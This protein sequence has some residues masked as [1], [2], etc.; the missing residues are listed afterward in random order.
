MPGQQ[1]MT[2][3]NGSPGGYTGSPNDARTCGTNGGC[4]GGGT[5]FEAGWITTDIPQ[6]GYSPGETYNITAT[7]DEGGTNKFG[8]E[9]SEED[10]S[11]NAKGT[12][13]ATTATQLKQSGKSITHRNN[14]TSGSD[15]KSW[16]FQWEAPAAGAGEVNFYAAFIAANGNN[17]NSGDNCYSSSLTIQEG[18]PA[19]VGNAAPEQTVSVWPNPAADAAFIDIPG[20]WAAP[21]VT[22]YNLSGKAVKVQRALPGTWQLPLTELDAGV[23]LVRIQSADKLATARLVVR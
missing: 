3:N 5:T 22:L 9:L 10:A 7:A 2:R 21:V 4:H 18:P 11:G 8:F 17:Q 1:A 6:V 19:F 16:T 20:S 13:I 23:Y 14:S 15:T 12:L